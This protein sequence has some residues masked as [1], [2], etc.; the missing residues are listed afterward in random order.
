M[1]TQEELAAYVEEL[2]RAEE[3]GEDLEQWE[4]LRRRWAPRPQDEAPHIADLWR[5]YEEATGTRIGCD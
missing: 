2:R 4:R 5:A 3:T 1:L